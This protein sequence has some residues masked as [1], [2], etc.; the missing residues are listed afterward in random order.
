MRSGA[1]RLGTGIWRDKKRKHAP[2]S[3]RTR[4]NGLEGGR[5]QD[6]GVSWQ[7]AEQVVLEGEVKRCEV[8]REMETGGVGIMGELEKRYVLMMTY[9][10]I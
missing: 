1:L 9:W 10:G 6:N 3:R 7:Q 4:R 2:Q 8:S 5:H